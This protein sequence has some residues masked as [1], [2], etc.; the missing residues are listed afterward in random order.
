MVEVVAVVVVVVL[1]SEETH[2][3]IT[4]A[5]MEQKSLTVSQKMLKCCV[6]TTDVALRGTSFPQATPFTFSHFVHRTKALL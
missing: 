6:E 5:S 4:N 2:F 1:L 3:Y